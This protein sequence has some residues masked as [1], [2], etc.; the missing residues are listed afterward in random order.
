MNSELLLS[1]KRFRWIS[2]M[3]YQAADGLYYKVNP[4][5]YLVDFLEARVGDLSWG[6]DEN[7][8][9]SSK[10]SFCI[11]F[12]QLLDVRGYH[13]SSDLIKEGLSDDTLSNYKMVERLIANAKID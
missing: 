8:R 11:N 2:T 6:A 5:K 10:I 3:Y 9:R 7:S 13:V 4:F 12:M 1:D